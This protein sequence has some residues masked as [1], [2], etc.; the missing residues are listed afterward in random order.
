MRDSP[1]NSKEASAENTAGQTFETD[2]EQKTLSDIGHSLSE[3]DHQRNESVSDDQVRHTQD[4]VE[5]VELLKTLMGETNFEEVTFQE[6]NE[7]L[8]VLVNYSDEIDLEPIK[9]SIGAI[10]VDDVEYSCEIT[11]EQLLRIFTDTSK[12][13]HVEK[14]KEWSEETLRDEMD[15]AKKWIKEQDALKPM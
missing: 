2:D 1:C 11:T 8:Q 6:N 15:E 12:I 9:Q 4:T 5:P 14:L 3:E 10:E 7:Q 13:Y